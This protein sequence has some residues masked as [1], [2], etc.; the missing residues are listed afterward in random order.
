MLNLVYSKKDRSSYN[1]F[2]AN[3]DSFKAWLATHESG[4]AFSY[5]DFNKQCN[6]TVPYSVV[7]LR[8][9]QR[10]NDG[11]EFKRELELTT[12]ERDLRDFVMNYPHLR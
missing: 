12:D 8:V 5:F 10:M 1:H 11:T 2:G 3:L 9:E 4:D 6:Q 7:K